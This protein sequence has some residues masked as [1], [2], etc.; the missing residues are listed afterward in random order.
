MSAAVRL[1]H[2]SI[3]VKRAER[4][5]EGV[6]FLFVP[7]LTQGHVLWAVTER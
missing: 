3:V 5:G 7:T 4:E 1:L 2:Q 6:D